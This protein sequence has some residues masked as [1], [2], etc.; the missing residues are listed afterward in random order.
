MCGA[1]T[2]TA[3]VADADLVFLVDSAGVIEA[4]GAVL[5]GSLAVSGPTMLSGGVELHGTLELTG[6]SGP[7]NA[8]LIAVR[9]TPGADPVFS[10]DGAGSLSAGAAAFG[11]VVVAASAILDS[12][13]LQVVF[14][15]DTIL[16]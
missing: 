4:G 15:N 5:R 16:L 10:V 13:G 9:G 14:S 8:V 12:E 11:R 6:A 2:G 3:A 7:A 1:G